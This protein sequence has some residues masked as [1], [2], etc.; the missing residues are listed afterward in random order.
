MNYAAETRT[1]L[2]H[3]WAQSLVMTQAQWATGTYHC[4]HQASI[5]AAE[6]LETQRILSLPRFRL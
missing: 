4:D 5:Q 2:L 1:G 6:K 3:P